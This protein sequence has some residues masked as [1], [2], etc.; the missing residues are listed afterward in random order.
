MN[1]SEKAQLIIGTVIKRMEAVETEDAQAFRILTLKDF[2]EALGG[3]YRGN[4]DEQLLSVEKDDVSKLTVVGGDRV[5]IHLLTQKAVILPKHCEGYVIPTNFVKV[6]LSTDT[7]APYFEWYFNNDPKIQ[8]Q[9]SMRAQGSVV[10]T[11]SVKQLRELE[12]KIPSMDKQQLIGDIYALRKHKA[13]LLEEALKLENQLLEQ[14][15]ISLGEGG[16]N[17]E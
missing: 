5:V 15:F 10:N 14:K 7:Y 3:H 11:F 16:T 13:A 2:N 1:I 12:I 6:E 8:K 17:H 9:I 4:T